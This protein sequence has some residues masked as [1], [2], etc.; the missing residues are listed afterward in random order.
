MDYPDRI[1]PGEPLPPSRPE[2]E[3]NPGR[4]PNAPIE[5][6]PNQPIQVPDSAP[7]IPEPEPELLAQFGKGNNGKPPKRPTLLADFFGG[8]VPNPYSSTFGAKNPFPSVD[9]V[10]QYHSFRNGLTPNNK[11]RAFGISVSSI[12]YELYALVIQ[13]HHPHTSWKKCCDSAWRFIV[14]HQVNHFLID[15]AVATLEGVLAISKSGNT[16]LWVNFHHQMHTFSALEESTCCAYSLRHA[17]NK[18]DALVLIDH[19]PS[20][21]D[22]ISDDGSEIITTS[23]SLSHQ[24]AVSR[25]LSLYIDSSTPYR[26]PGLHNLMQ[27]ESH[28]KGNKGDLFFNFPNGGLKTIQIR[29]G[30]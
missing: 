5:L 29:L 21:Y 13:L 11:D 27:Y 17:P 30:H 24:K 25:L 3:F 16:N 18:S 20:G 28:L 7:S 1:T 12:G 2:I 26:Q 15:R 22:A 8:F 9:H 14:S 10:S 19:Q 23:E 6:T 4:R